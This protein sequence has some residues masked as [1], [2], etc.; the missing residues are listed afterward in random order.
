MNRLG[1]I[2][3]YLLA[4]LLIFIIIYIITNQVREHHLQ[5]D[6]MLYTLR[7]ILKPVHPVFQHLQLYK[8]DKSYTINKEKTFLCLYDENGD[9]YPLNM[10]L[11][12]VLHEAAH[13]LNTEDIGHTEAFYRQFDQ[14]LK[15]AAQLGIYNPSIPIIQNYCN[16]NG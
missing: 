16:Y 3:T 9:Y 5:D 15:R 7:E 11:H 4:T 2:I 1:K 10:I 8:G 13:V 12:V 6:P 14:L